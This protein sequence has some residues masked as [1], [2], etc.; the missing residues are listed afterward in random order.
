MLAFFV[1]FVAVLSVTNVDAKL[2]PRKRITQRTLMEK[3]DEYADLIGDYSAKLCMQKLEGRPN[4]EAR[5]DYFSQELEDWVRD[6]FSK[7]GHSTEQSHRQMLRT[8]SKFHN[9]ME[10]RRLLTSA[11]DKITY[12]KGP[13]GRK[14]IHDALS[15]MNQFLLNIGVG[16][17]SQA[18]QWAKI[19]PGTLKKLRSQGLSIPAL[20]EDFDLEDIMNPEG[21]W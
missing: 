8:G 13:L 6:L 18:E 19:P 1:A 14:D 4:Y 3:Y 11:L 12:M 20:D 15:D 10:L 2:D 7:L 9:L 21:E 5:C 17:Q 16:S